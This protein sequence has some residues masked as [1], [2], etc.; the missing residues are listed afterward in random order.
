MA[1]TTPI[2]V[3]VDEE[4]KA[5]LKRAA[6]DDDRSQ[7]SMMERILKQWLR[8]HEYLPK[9]SKAAGKRK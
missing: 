2:G 1:Q 5:A 3:R 8:E 6:D 7:A 4:T 9:A